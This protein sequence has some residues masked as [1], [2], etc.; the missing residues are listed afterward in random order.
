MTT[1]F[2]SERDYIAAE[3]LYAKPRWGRIVLDVSIFLL[4]G[5]A[6]V[7]AVGVKCGYT[8]YEQSVA[9]LK[10][11]IF[12]IVFLPVARVVFLIIKHFRLRKVYRE[13]PMLHAEANLIWCESGLQAESKY[14]T[15]KFNWDELHGW[16]ENANYLLLLISKYQYY[17][18]PK[19]A[20]SAGEL[21][22][23]KQHL[24]A[25]LKK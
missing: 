10:F 21:D 22:D 1:I 19:L 6:M 20:F 15:L 11:L 24:P 17:I 7:V 25:S 8:S 2:V 13:T 12:Y 3:R 4:V 9:V 23:L 5:V 14:G 18:L 16:R